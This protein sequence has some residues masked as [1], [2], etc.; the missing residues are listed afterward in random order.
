MLK[1]IFTVLLSIVLFACTSIQL[2]EMVSENDWQAVGEH[3]ANLG[4]KEYSSAQLQVLSDKYGNGEVDYSRYRKGYQQGLSIY[5]QPEHASE[6]GAEGKEYLGICGRLPHGDK[7]RRDWELAK[8]LR[9][10]VM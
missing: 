6:L 2:K 1:T 3:H 4:M 7:F 10:T 8:D 5:C 9:S